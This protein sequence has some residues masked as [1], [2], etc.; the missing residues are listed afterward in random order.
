MPKSFSIE[1]DLLSSAD[2][3]CR[4]RLNDAVG[5]SSSDTEVFVAQSSCIRIA[6]LPDTQEDTFRWAAV[7]VPSTLVESS[8]EKIDGGP[9]SASSAFS[10]IQPS[11]RKELS[12]GL[13]TSIHPYLATNYAI[14]AIILLRNE[15]HAPSDIVMLDLSHSPPTAIDDLMD[16]TNCQTVH[17]GPEAILKVILVSQIT[18]LLPGQK[19]TTAN[20]ASLTPQRTDIPTCP[21]CLHRIDPL[22]LG[23]PKPRNRHLCSK[24][25]RSPSLVSSHEDSCPQQRLL[26]P[27]PRPSHCLACQIIQTYWKDDFDESMDL[28]C[29]SCAMQETLWVCLTCGFVGCGRYSNKHAAEHFN[30]TGHPY[31]LEL[32]T[33]RIWE[34]IDGEFA[35][36]VDL[37][38]CPSSPPMLHPWSRKVPRHQPLHSNY[39]DH[40]RT[41]TVMVDEKSP[42]KATMIGEEYEALLQSALE[43]QAHYYEGEITRLRAALT[44][45]QVDQESMTKEDAE[46][47]D[48]LQKEI[49]KLRKEIDCTGRELLDSQAQEAG[50][51][52]TSQHLLRGQQVAQELLKK[53]EAE[54]A[55]EYEQG[56]IQVEDLEQ[57]IADLTANQRMRH[58]F[59]QDEELANSQIWGTS[60]ENNRSSKKGK[61][62]RRLFRK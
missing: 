51:R 2:E 58:Q 35:H 41:A 52:A 31:S 7:F 40:D 10:A 13:L 27:W 23:L 55:R 61:K 30:D 57:Q 54:A 20:V 43:E 8:L 49:A 37:L 1:A 17:S 48:S 5:E 50:H 4:D 9:F 15:Q 45:E 36:R 47:I 28:F 39:A 46:E 44:A 12:Q 53:I 62:L 21:V 24:F 60:G 6:P 19:S 3:E 33:L 26:Q 29:C 38:E 16:T 11:H 14:K 34:Y 56:R 59:S 18:F 32:A 42:K 25:C 22:R